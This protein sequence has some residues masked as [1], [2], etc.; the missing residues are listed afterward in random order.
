MV[1]QL[2]KKKENEKKTHPI[3]EMGAYALRSLLSVYA[4]KMKPSVNYSRPVPV[5]TTVT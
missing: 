2:K 1:F 5:M 4:S 3:F